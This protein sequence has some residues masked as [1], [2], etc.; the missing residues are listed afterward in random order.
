MRRAHGPSSTGL[1]VGAL[2][3]AGSGSAR[4]DLIVGGKAVLPGAWAV[5]YGQ[6]GSPAG[7]SV[8]GDGDLVYDTEIQVYVLYSGSTPVPL[9]VS[10]EQYDPGTITEYV[11]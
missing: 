11:N 3:L 4:G 8:F 9:E 2:L 10:I 6:G 1:V 7:K 5:P